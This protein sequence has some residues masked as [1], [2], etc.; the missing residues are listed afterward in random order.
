MM[1]DCENIKIVEI[2]SPPYDAF[3]LLFYYFV[4]KKEVVIHLIV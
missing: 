4:I 2:P 1:D 3:T